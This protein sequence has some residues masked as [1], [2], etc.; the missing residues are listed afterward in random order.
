[1]IRPTRI[2][3]CFD[4]ILIRVDFHHAM[5]L[6]LLAVAGQYDIAALHLGGIHGRNGHNLVIL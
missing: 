4:P 6:E 2:A 5:R 1:M 3:P